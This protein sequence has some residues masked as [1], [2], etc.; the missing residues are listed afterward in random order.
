M[1]MLNWPLLEEAESLL[2]SCSPVCM[3]RRR[4]AKE[5][6]KRGGGQPVSHLPVPP[7]SCW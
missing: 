6:R 2:H 5:K 1:I 3:A 7:R 4:R